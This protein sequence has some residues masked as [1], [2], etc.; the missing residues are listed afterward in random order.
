MV[1]NFK[2]KQLN[3]GAQEAPKEAVEEVKTPE[4]T[5]V[6]TEAVQAPVEAPK[7][8]KEEAPAPATIE[9]PKVEAK[10]APKEEPKPA[11][12]PEVK[13][14]KPAKQEAKQ[15]APKQQANT[16][17]FA[18]QVAEAK[19]SESPMLR[20][21]AQNMEKYVEG[22]TPGKVIAPEMI[23]RF[24]SML[25]S[26]IKRVVE[27]PKDFTPCFNLIIEFFRNYTLVD[28]K[29]HVFHADYLFRG[30]EHTTMSYI[31]SKHFF[32]M[33][34]TLTLAAETK[35]RKQVT[36]MVDLNRVLSHQVFSDAGRNRVI[37]YFQG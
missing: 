16:K 21:V 3:G 24:Q 8:V 9:K 25:W 7:P 12:A 27:S 1:K 22:M 6:A 30:A 15:E 19:A 32:G 34:N 11:S 23:N 36:S 17:T 20:M 10:V 29:R 4:A 13:E 37:N 2:S 5:Q 14:A 28:G 35:N 31:Q 33:L 26:T 18:D